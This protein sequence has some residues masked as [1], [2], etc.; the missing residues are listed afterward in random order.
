MAHL[1]KKMK[2][3]RPYYYIREIAR[4]GGKPK[5]VNQIYLGSLERI[6]ELAKG[7]ER[8]L[9]KLSA[10]EYGAL[11]LANEI[12]RQV[13]LAS[14]V[15][16]VL[17][18]GENET[19]PS[20]GDYFLYA[21]FNRMVDPCSKRALPDWYRSTAVQH[22]RP[23]D[24]DAL[25]SQRYWERWSRVWGK[26][27][28]KIATAFLERISR[29][30]PPESDCFLFDTTNYYTYMA[31][32]TESE[33]AVRGKNKEGKD[34]LRQIGVALLVSRNKQLPLFYREYEG[35]RHDS[36][37][38]LQILEEVL[39]AMKMGAKGKGELT[40]VFDKFRGA[41]GKAESKPARHFRT[42]LG[43]MANFFYTLQ[44]EAAGAQA[45]SSV[46]TYLA[47]FIA[48]DRLSYREVKQAIQEWVFNLNVPTRVG[49]QTPFT[50]ITIDWNVPERL[51]NERIIIGGEICS[52]TYDQYQH[53]M[54]M[55]NRAFLEVMLEGDAKGR[56]F[57]FPIPTYNI[58]PDFDYGDP[59]LAPLWDVTAR[60]GI[61]CFA[62][63]VNS[64]LSPDD[65]R[66]MR[67][68]LRLDTRQL[69]HRGGGLFG[70]NPLTG[71]IGV[72]TLN[73]PRLGHLAQDRADFFKRIE[74]LMDIAQISLTIKRKVLERFTDAHLYPYARYYLRDIKQ[75]TGE[76]WQ[77]HFST[78]GI[79]GLDEA[80]RNLL[81]EGL[82]GPDG[83]IFG[84][85]VLDRMRER[86]VA[87]QEQTGVPFNL[88]AT[89]AE[90]TSYRLA[91]LDRQRFPAMRIHGGGDETRE[92]AYSNSSQP[93]V[94]ALHDPFDLLD[95]QDD[96]QSRYTGGTIL[97]FW[98][99]ER[100]EDPSTVKS[101][102][103]TVCS[104]YRLPYFT[105]T[106][107]FSIC[108]RHGYLVGEKKSCPDCNT[109]AEVYSRVVGYLRPVGQ[110][111]PGKKN[112]FRRRATFD[113]GFA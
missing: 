76:Y 12:D 91:L 87:Y 21:V 85:E 23:V 27:L 5:V 15:D 49:F 40:L 82:L 104:R 32:D 89:P 92:A 111:N 68:R 94:D 3:G 56:V 34:R 47:P 53:E 99:G 60:Y 6:M 110:W 43:R 13:G 8:K 106:P 28:R 54:D 58:T 83:R 17:P 100:V 71:S 31:S 46:D 52:E 4:V 72:V 51:Q 113:G 19:G 84:L 29:L 95:H 14:L 11:W 98:L 112:E 45:F 61:P 55:F 48:R 74:R 65:A 59:R 69:R 88:E 50:N 44:G 102:I 1:R 105:L 18:K 67:C 70:A 63:F 36:K 2:N 78:I 86:L 33:L 22:I 20:V 7:T 64:S 57:T 81:G 93:P 109:P 9:Q 97:H 39:A 10:Q 38:F 80:S 108:P 103:R 25:N 26:D 16:S 75:R 37:I 42:A 79:V 66:S 96:F 73:L 101:F 77:N 35:N 107:T 90:G 62:N 24:V 30:E 41:G